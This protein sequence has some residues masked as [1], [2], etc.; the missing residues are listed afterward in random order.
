MQIDWNR[1]TKHFESVPR[2][3]LLPAL[4]ASLLQVKPGFNLDLLKTYADSHSR[5]AFIKTA[6]LRIMGT[7]E[8]QLC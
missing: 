1:F 6:T 8:Y 5:E 2:E 7:P 4:S 3:Q